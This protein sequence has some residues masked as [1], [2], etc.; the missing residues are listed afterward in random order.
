MNGLVSDLPPGARDDLAGGASLAA[1]HPYFGA[2]GAARRFVEL[3][4]APYLDDLAA[5]VGIIRCV[6]VGGGEGIV[7]EAF[8]QWCQS[9]AKE[10]RVTVLDRNEA[11]LKT[12]AARGLH[13]Q[14]GGV[15]DLAPASADCVIYRFVNHYN[16]EL[17]QARIA[18][19]L[20]RLVRYGGILAAQIETGSA[21]TCRLL[22]EIAALLSGDDVARGRHWPTRAAFEASYRAVGFE[23]EAA[24]G[25]DLEE[26]VSSEERLDQAW[27]RVVGATL[28][29]SLEGGD[30]ER[31]AQILDDRNNFLRSARERLTA[32]GAGDMIVTCQ[33]LIVMRRRD[34]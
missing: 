19:A 4:F 3:A 2:A 8:T 11:F 20:A 27:T 24:H 34:T 18:G 12:A 31:A 17:E 22:G 23:V 1:L 9:A 30:A 26:R 6:D 33:P 28:W 21:A 32:A 15:E 29:S 7:A 25:S 14:L 5:D 13:V 16:K 10:C